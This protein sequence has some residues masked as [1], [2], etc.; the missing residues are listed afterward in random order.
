VSSRIRQ[1]N[2][3]TSLK[4]LFPS[5]TLEIRLYFRP[6]FFPHSDY[7]AFPSLTVYGNI[8]N[9]LPALRRTGQSNDEQSATTIIQLHVARR[10]QNN[11]KK[12]LQNIQM[13]LFRP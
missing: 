10:P 1:V 12:Y 6:A 8:F 4:I 7:T 11:Q 13:A 3:C 2:A 9:C 5:L